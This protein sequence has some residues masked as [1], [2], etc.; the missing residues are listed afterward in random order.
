MP[1]TH[2]NRVRTTVSAVASAGLGAF[3]ISTA[4]SGYRSFVAGDDGK[5]FDVLITEG[6]TWEVR[7]GCTYTHSGT[8][9]ARGTLEDSSTGSAI[10]FTSAAIV[11]V[12]AT[13]AF[14][15]SAEN[16][17]Q[18]VTPGGRLT[19][20]SGTPVTTSD[21]TGATSIYYTPYVS[22]IINLWD[23]SEWV[24]T[25]FSETTE[26][27]GTLTSGL[28]YDVFGFLASGVLD[29]EKLAWT[30]DT[31]R[32][33]AIT[34]QDGRY[35]KSGDKTRLYLGTFRTTSTTT[36]EDSFGGT[37]SQVG[38]KRFVWNMYNR[39]RRQLRVKDTTDSWSASG[40]V[41]RQANGASGNKVE[42]VLGLAVDSV[43]AN[44]VGNVYKPS[45]AAHYTGIGLDS[46]TASTGSI[47]AIG[48]S[49]VTGNQIAALFG[50]YV[51]IPAAGYHYL[52][53][54]ERSSVTTGAT[55]NGDSGETEGSGQQ[56]GLNAEIFA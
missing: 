46:T 35:C 49:E 3:T 56:S 34:L 8:S 39:V 41:Y 26:A 54:L 45:N 23:G 42:F 17:F 37:T 21:V 20:T 31:T 12:T 44:A 6:T 27:L 5:T 53:W 32:A 10:A 19:L 29:L 1:V 48:Y 43:T 7:T 47:T 15:N 24:P 25:I 50:M 30:N 40:T 4:S 22:N 33:T 13:A 11:T 9:L 14:G 38:G 52:A 16:T 51:G 55:W 18:S 28:N 2:K 36:T